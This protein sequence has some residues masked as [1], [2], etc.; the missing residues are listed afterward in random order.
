MESP[1]TWNIR[2]RYPSKIYPFTSFHHSLLNWNKTTRCPLLDILIHC[3]WRF[4]LGLMANI[5]PNDWWRWHSQSIALQLTSNVTSVTL[6]YFI[7]Y[8]SVHIHPDQSIFIHCTIHFH[9]HSSRIQ[10]NQYTIKIT[11]PTS[12]H[13]K[14]KTPPQNQTSLPVFESICLNPL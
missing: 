12:H 6:L 13:V 5:C 7:Q 9:I 4:S 2:Q 10:T 1:T 3:S 14:P 11:S 8:H